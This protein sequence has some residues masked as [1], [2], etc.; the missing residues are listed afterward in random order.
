MAFIKE[1]IFKISS[2]IEN[3]TPSGLTDGEPERTEITLEGF[4]KTDGESVEITYTDKTEGG[5][6]VSVITAEPGCVRVVRRGG[7]ES[8]MIFKT[9]EIHKS[10]YTVSPY[11]FD[12]EVRCRKIRYGLTRSGGRLEVFYD[13]SIGGADKSVRMRIDCTPK[14]N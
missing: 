9:G 5:R 6:V 1:M 10:L 2:V 8:D 4:Y 3:L 12:T 11:S 13:M 7:V 14:E